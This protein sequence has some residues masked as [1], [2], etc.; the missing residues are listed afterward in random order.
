MRIL[1]R[2]LAKEFF[3]SLALTITSL[4][5]IYSIIE[6]FEKIDDVGKSSHGIGY[7][8]KYLY[9]S[10]PQILL[11]ILPVAFLIAVLLTL[12]LLSRNRELLAIKAGG[13]S[14]YRA[15]YALLVIAALVCALSFVFRETILT[16]SNQM[17][18]YYQNL[19]AGKKPGKSL[20]K[21]QTWF[22]GSK[23]RIF[24]VQL[25]NAEFQEIHGIIFFEL[26]SQFHVIRRVD[27]Q[28]GAYR[29]GTWYF[30][31][32]I[33]RTFGPD[34]L[35][36]IS[37]REFEQAT[38]P[39]PEPF[40]DLFSLQ[41]LPEEMTYQELSQYIERLQEAGYRTN[42][43]RVDL[44]SKISMSFITFIMALI[45][46][47]FAVKIDR[48]AR[49]F[50]I[51]LGLLIS[52]LYWVVFFISVSLGHAGAIPP[53]LAAWLGNAIFFC[54]ALYLFMTIPT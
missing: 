53:V 45:G 50:N 1:D 33:E 32:G 7:A 13:I 12:S 37:F 6:F 42:K 28:R 18:L 30:Y 35:S 52:F 47:S 19:M 26:D 11:Q 44:H 48:S 23:K 25:V 10:M 5:G 51:G 40:E 38:F 3:R 31:H 17:A 22:W 21:S 8:L 24:N 34:R 20:K 14:L 54:F 15:S 36:K 41:K 9:Y 43:Y 39:I 16:R 46:I 2:Y 4:I 29:H 49:L 27:A